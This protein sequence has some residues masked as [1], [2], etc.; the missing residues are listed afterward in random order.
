M[1]DVV[2]RWIRDRSELLVVRLQ[3]NTRCTMAKGVYSV[4]SKDP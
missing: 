3:K 1:I 2:S 4:Q